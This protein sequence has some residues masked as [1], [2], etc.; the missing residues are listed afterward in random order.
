MS[1]ETDRENEARLS[2]R[3]A[4]LSGAGWRG[5]ALMND[6]LSIRVDAAPSGKRI[7]A[8]DGT[9][10]RLEKCPSDPVPIQ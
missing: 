4:V 8:A 10:L 3:H 6:R 7:E 1:L 2:F 9:L 5:D